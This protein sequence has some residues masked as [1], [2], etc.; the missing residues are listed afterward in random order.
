MK[1]LSGHYT[2]ETAFVQD[3]YPYGFKLKCSRRVWLDVNNK[4]CRLITQTTNP[5]K[6]FISWNAPKMSTYAAVGV[7]YQRGDE[8]GEEA[9]HVEWDSWSEYY[10][11]KARGFLDTYREGL[12][13]E[14]IALLER[15]AAAY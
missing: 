13:P 6:P 8:A 15:V 3:G 12:L 4:G 7:L 1:I 2:A 10:P 11:G 5:K 9:G 14:Q